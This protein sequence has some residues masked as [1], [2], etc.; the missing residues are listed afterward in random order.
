M[1][2]T[3]FPACMRC[4]MLYHMPTSSWIV[5][6]PSSCLQ[7]RCRCACKRA[8]LESIEHQRR[9]P[10]RR[11]VVEV[12]RAVRSGH[13][14]ADC[15]T[16]EARGQQDLDDPCACSSFD[17]TEHTT[18]SHSWLINIYGCISQANDDSAHHRV[19]RCPADLEF[20]HDAAFSVCQSIKAQPFNFNFTLDSSAAID[21]KA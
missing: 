1:L 9:P 20:K 18:R 19:K 6:H 16:T 4:L 11:Y 5:H 8:H 7:A 15:Y 17:A 3:S 10:L 12:V 13:P 2:A 14:Y 21:S